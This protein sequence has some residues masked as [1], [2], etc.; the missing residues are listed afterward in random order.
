MKLYSKALILF[1][2]TTSMILISIGSLA[3]LVTK[4]YPIAKR[5]VLS[6]VKGRYGLLTKK[7]NGGLSAV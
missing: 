2:F 7:P 4:Y 3:E 5:E 1:Y 6:F